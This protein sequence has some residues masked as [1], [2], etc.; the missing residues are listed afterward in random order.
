MNIHLEL[1]LTFLVIYGLELCYC[2]TYRAA[3]LEHAV[4][5]PDPWAPDRATALNQ[6]MVNLKTYEEQ[7]HIAGK[8]VSIIRYYQDDNHM[9]NWHL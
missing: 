1:C 8:E 4:V 2:L 5:F 3:V 9:L 6:M 7:A